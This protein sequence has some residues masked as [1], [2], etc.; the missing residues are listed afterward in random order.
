MF[1]S[2]SGSSWAVNVNGS[3]SPTLNAWNHVAIVRN[4]TTLTMYLNGTS[5]ATASISGSLYSSSAP[6]TIGQDQSN[7]GGYPFYGYMS[8][9]RVVNGTA[10]YTSNFT[11]STTP[12]TAITNTSLLTL[13]N[14]GFVDN[15]S[16]AFALTLNG[17]PS[18]ATYNPF[19]P[20]AN[21][22][23]YSWSNYL[24]NNSSYLTVPTSSNLALGSGS[25]TIEFWMFGINNTG[26]LVRPLSDIAVGGGFGANSYVFTVGYQGY[27]LGFYA[28]N[29]NGST[30]PTLAST[31]S[32]I[33]NDHTWHH[34]AVCRNGNSWYMFID[35][36]QQG[37][38]LTSSV[39]LDNGTSAP[40]TIGWSGI[41]GDT[42][43]NGYISNLR[44]IKGTALYTSNFTPS[45]TPLTAI[46]GTQ[47]LTCQSGSYIDNSSNNFTISQGG[48]PIIA[49]QNPFG[50]SYAGG[51][52]GGG[53]SNSYSGSGGMG[54]GANGT[55]GNT[56]TTPTAA[57]ANT[58]GGGGGETGGGGGSG[59]TGGSGIVILAYPSTYPDASSVTNGTKTTSGGW[60]IYTFLTSGSIT[61]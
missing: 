46:S 26:T 6:T 32:T 15:S 9:Y 14:S 35:G 51:G 38:T 23:T 29:Y 4:G 52:G 28:Y 58:G 30:G 49:S 37:S 12:L 2:T 48:T 27:G 59:G 21:P 60:K 42:A 50:A 34:V 25:F 47:L 39:A 16:N 19:A 45:S 61:F 54:G 3:T 22:A 33:S 41:S 20:I 43:F 1:A 7:S 56:S 31:S 13:Q 36:V 44:I 53:G 40:V 5:I 55:G 18:P 57:L 11:P 8:N 17:S 10:V 24:P